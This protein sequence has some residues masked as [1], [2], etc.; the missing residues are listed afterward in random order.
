MAEKQ[1]SIEE[2]IKNLNEMVDRIENE[3]MTLSES[4]SL[5]ESAMKL[6]KEIEE[7]LNKTIDKIKIIQG[8]ED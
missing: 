6:S 5:Y 2:K 3:K 1:L 7:E 8:D 4:L